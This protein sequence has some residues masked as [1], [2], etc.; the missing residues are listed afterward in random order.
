MSINFQKKK[1]KNNIRLLFLGCAP[2]K[3]H[4]GVRDLFLYQSQ[5]I[6]CLGLCGTQGKTL[7]SSEDWDLDRTHI[8]TFVEHFTKHF[9]YLL[10]YIQDRSA[11]CLR[12]STFP[13]SDPLRDPIV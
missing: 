8:F 3:C 6:P 9:F 13:R 11:E 1:K 4:Q 2:P 7:I 10:V 12:E 5:K